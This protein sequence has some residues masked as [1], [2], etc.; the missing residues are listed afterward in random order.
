[1]SEEMRHRHA[2]H[3]KGCI[4]IYLVVYHPA[5]TTLQIRFSSEN[6]GLKTVQ[7]IEWAVHL[8]LKALFSFAHEIRPVI[9]L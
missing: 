3:S 2:V 5:S 8:S 1:M 9:P 6:W 4:V 7:A